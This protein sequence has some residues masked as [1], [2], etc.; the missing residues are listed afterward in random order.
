LFC[1]ERLPLLI[2]C[3]VPQNHTVHNPQPGTPAATVVLNPSD[4][5][6]FDFGLS[7]DSPSVLA[8]PFNPLYICLHV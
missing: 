1:N 6:P 7:L 8:Q 4:S 5:L 2:L 3:T